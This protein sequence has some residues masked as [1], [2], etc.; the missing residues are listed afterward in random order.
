MNSLENKE[1]TRLLLSLASF[2]ISE[3]EIYEKFMWVQTWGSSSVK[4][5]RAG[6]TDRCT[7]SQMHPDSY[8]HCSARNL[9]LSKVCKNLK[10]DIYKIS[11][12]KNLSGTNS[13]C[14]T[15]HFI[16]FPL[17]YIVPDSYSD[18]FYLDADPKA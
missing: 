13:F 15:F 14:I 8:T 1:K 12:Q 16:L 9:F 11:E 5:Q 4:S 6:L 2:S 17:K 18:V 7:A 3:E 10:C